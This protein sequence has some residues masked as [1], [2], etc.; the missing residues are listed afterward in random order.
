MH[1]MMLSKIF[2]TITGFLKAVSSGF[3]ERK[4]S[5]PKISPVKG[6]NLRIADLMRLST[7]SFRFRLSRTILTILGVSVGIGAILFL[8]AL[9]N[10]LQ[11]LLLEK[12]TT[13]EALLSLDVAPPASEIIELDNTSLDSIRAMEH[14]QDVARL[15]TIP[16]QMKFGEL[17]A[18]VLV[19][20]IDPSFFKYSGISISEGAAF[21][22]EENGSA[23]SHCSIVRIE[24]VDVVLSAVGDEGRIKHLFS[25]FVESEGKSESV[26][27]V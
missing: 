26:E 21:T 19:N 25:C 23:N 1:T 15:A 18:D 2:K 13:D 10:G 12:I 11:Q 16:S 7:R 3:S 8:V 24:D 5:I 9:G 20:A 22:E 4:I 14:V 27:V 6:H 17:N